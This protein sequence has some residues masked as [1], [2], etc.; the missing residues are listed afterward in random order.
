MVCYK[1]ALRVRCLV[2]GDLHIS[3]TNMLHN[4]G[5]VLVDKERYKNAIMCLGKTLGVKQNELGD[6]FLSFLYRLLKIGQVHT[7]TIFFDALNLE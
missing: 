3:V 7:T 1:E 2:F 4:L 6:D 5:S